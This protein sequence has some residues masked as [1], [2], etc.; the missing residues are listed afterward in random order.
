MTTPLAQT[1]IVHND[2]AQG[3]DGLFVTKVDVYFKQKDPLV[4][5]TVEIRLTENGV[6]TK[7]TIPFSSIHIDNASIGVSNTAVNATSITFPAPIFLKTSAEYALV[8][9]PDGNSPEFQIW[10][11][12]TG[13]TDVA[14]PSYSVR[15]DWGEGALFGSTNNSTWIPI[16]GETLKFNL[17]RASFN[18]SGTFT[19]TNKNDE[20]F[21]VEGVYNTFQH[22]EPVFQFTNTK[23]AGTVAFANT[24]TTVTGTGTAFLSAVSVGSSLVLANTAV[25][26]PVNHYDIAKIASIAN[27]TSLTL[28]RKPNFSATGAAALLTPTGIVSFYNANTA[29]LIVTDST[30]ANNSFKFTNNSVIVGAVSLARGTIM[31]IDNKVI[32]HY[33]PLFYKTSVLGTNIVAT[34]TQMDSAYQVRDTVSI[35]M[36]DTNYNTKYATIIASR[37]NEITAGSGKSVNIPVTFSSTSAFVSPTLDLQSTSVLRYSNYING[38]NTGENGPTGAAWSKS[39]T[40]TVVLADGQDAEDLKIILTGY[41]P[42]GTAIEVYA[43][44]LSSEDPDILK[45]KAWTKLVNTA[46]TFCDP[47]NREDFREFT[48][49]IPNVP[50]QYFASPGVV[51]GLN[52][53]VDVTGI[54]T[55]FPLNLA[56]NDTIAI[57]NQSEDVFVTSVANVVSNTALTLS[58]PLPWAVTGASLFLFRDPDVA[59]ADPQNDGVISYFSDSGKFSTFK[60]YAIKIVLLASTSYIVP[61]VRDV[62]AIAL[63]V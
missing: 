54:N 29:E 18:S 50:T 42:T 57:V 55:F 12:A 59:F 62:R 8:I 7:T 41:Q 46:H 35:R 63:S 17:Y 38:D 32:D 27:N 40:K 28:D 25:P 60:T 11:A 52:A 22:G 49:S 47:A 20:Y 19:L 6:P 58:T 1:F 23:L 39:I 37:S 16:P 51:S 13:Q 15:H 45:D 56:N 4:G 36:N 31:S 53:N 2:Y 61:R 44:V 14:N 48:Y 26:T 5:V 9:I 33:Q 43:R 24:S 34:Y 21:S 10:T 3:Q 30:A